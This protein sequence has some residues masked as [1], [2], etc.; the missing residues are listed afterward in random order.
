MEIFE[1]EQDF[2]KS[3]L[4]KD[5]SIQ[6]IYSTV[7]ER[8]AFAYSSLVELMQLFSTKKEEFI[9]E[10]QF[11]FSISDVIDVDNDFININLKLLS[12]PHALYL[13]FVLNRNRE[14]IDPDID[15]R[16]TQLYKQHSNII[17]IC[18]IDLPHDHSRHSILREKN[19]KS[20]LESIAGDLIQDNMTAYACY[21]IENNICNAAIS[22][23]C[24]SI[25]VDAY[26]DGELDT[27]KKYRIIPNFIDV[28]NNSDA[29]FNARMQ[30]SLDTMQY[31]AVFC[32]LGN[33]K[34]CTLSFSTLLLDDRMYELFKHS[35]KT[36]REYYVD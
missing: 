19:Y 28:I 1:F 24:K 26:N 11:K 30:Y 15:V 33:M 5:S 27:D 4:T 8:S 14:I 17:D 21:D 35:V 29:E 2:L 7:R 22:P 12:L 3:C 36:A 34:G 25:F 32:A 10:N 20:I 9:Y 18:S 23:N 16:T 6:E 13:K 31:N